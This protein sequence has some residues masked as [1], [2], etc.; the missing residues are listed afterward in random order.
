MTQHLLEGRPM[1][2]D[3]RRITVLQSLPNEEVWCPFCFEKQK[4]RA[5]R[6]FLDDGK[7]SKMVRCCVCHRRMAQSSMKILFQG[8]KQ[9]GMFI[10]GYSRFWFTIDHADWIRKL[11]ATFKPNE[12]AEFWSGYG[13]MR[14]E[15]KE[16]QRLDQLQR[17]YEAAGRR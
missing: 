8:P 7:L 10:G 17:D 12:I 11:K 2:E 16:K 6:F 1:D 5:T 3:D 14:P 9:F 4:A 15:F 13:G